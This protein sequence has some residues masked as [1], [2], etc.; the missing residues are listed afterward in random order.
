M[1]R[2]VANHKC[3]DAPSE[4]LQVAASDWQRRHH[5]FLNPCG[6]RPQGRRRRSQKHAVPVERGPR[7]T[8]GV[9]LSTGFVSAPPSETLY[10]RLRPDDRAPRPLSSAWSQPHVGLLW[11]RSR[12]S[13]GRTEG[14]EEPSSPGLCLPRPRTAHSETQT[15]TSWRLWA[16]A[17]GAGLLPAAGVTLGAPCQGPGL[18]PRARP[19]PRR[20]AGSSGAPPAVLRSPAVIRGHIPRSPGLLLLHT[21]G[22][23][24][25]PPPPEGKRPAQERSLPLW[26]SGIPHSG[27]R[28]SSFRGSGEGWRRLRSPLSLTWPL[29]VCLSPPFLGEQWS[30]A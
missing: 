16:L 22:S 4:F 8:C 17:A 5:W 23:H 7:L 29:R 11:A 15:R 14:A 3:Q 28:P 18:G 9:R 12:S 21:C 20:R 2:P 1:G 27:G 6:A 30:L 19:E 10:E 24:R 25:A 13:C 26:R